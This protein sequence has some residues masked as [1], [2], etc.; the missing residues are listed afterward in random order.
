MEAGGPG[1]EPGKS[2][3]IVDAL[4][5]KGSYDVRL[6][7]A[8]PRTV[9]VSGFSIHHPDEADAFPPA[10]AAGTESMSLRAGQTVLLPAGMPCELSGTDAAIIGA[11]PES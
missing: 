11:S 7:S 4:R 1:A 5:A 9:T 8:H 3:V 10:F 6:V 2:V